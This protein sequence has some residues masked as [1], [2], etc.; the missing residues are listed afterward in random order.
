VQSVV[1]ALSSKPA[2]RTCPEVLSANPDCGRLSGIT[3]RT[4]AIFY[5]S[6][7]L[8]RNNDHKSQHD[9]PSARAVHHL[10]HR[11]TI[12]Y[13][14]LSDDNTGGAVSTT[15]SAA[16]KQ[17]KTC[18]ASEF[19]TTQYNGKAVSL[20]GNSRQR[21]LPRPETRARYKHRRH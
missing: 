21:S 2:P 9:E 17:K 6:L 12:L 5:R 13:W 19:W 16:R 18:V 4:T 3:L 20:R 8:Q 10:T 11:I 14:K 1:T 7:R 15:C